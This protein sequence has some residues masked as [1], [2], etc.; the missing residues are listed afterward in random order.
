MSEP[1]FIR[2]WKG[3]SEIPN[4]SA[5][6]ILEVEKCCGRLKLKGER[7]YVIGEDFWGQVLTIGHYL[8][9][10]TFYGSK[11]EFSTQLLQKCGFNV[12]LANW[13]ELEVSCDGKV[14]TI[15][16]KE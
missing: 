14:I 6:H 4:E 8:S 15:E 2:N 9:T 16:K 13:D 1:K 3:L 11:H 10:H 5:T 7:K 12:V